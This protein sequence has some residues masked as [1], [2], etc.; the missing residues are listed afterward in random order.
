MESRPVRYLAVVFALPL[1]AGLAVTTL[2]V[3]SAQILEVTMRG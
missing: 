2:V 3:L 1:L